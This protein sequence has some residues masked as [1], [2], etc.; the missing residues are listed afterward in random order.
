MQI[1]SLSIIIE[2]KFHLK[3]HVCYFLLSLSK[4]FITILIFMLTLVI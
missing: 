2:G 4:F 3:S 1:C